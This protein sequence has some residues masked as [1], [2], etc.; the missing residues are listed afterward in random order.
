MRCA[1]WYHLYNLKKREKH[2]WR[3]LTFSKVEGSHL[4]YGRFSPWEFFCFLQFKNVKN[5]H[6]GVKLQAQA[7][8]FA[9]SNTPLWVFFTFF[10]LYKWYQ[11]AQRNTFTW[12]GT[13]LW[14]TSNTKRCGSIFFFLQEIVTLQ[15]DQPISGQSSYFISPENI[16][17][18]KI[19]QCFHWVYWK[20]WP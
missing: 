1:I 16:K 12:W 8:N 11:I 13:P 7:W 6:S 15:C 10:K 5:K 20:H 2:P 9:K 14:N 19:S 4:F 17:I 3:S 18:S